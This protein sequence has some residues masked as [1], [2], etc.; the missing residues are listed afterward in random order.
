MSNSSEILHIND[1]LNDFAKRDNIDPEFALKLSQIRYS[2]LSKDII[3]FLIPKLKSIKLPLSELFYGFAK[4]FHK[5][6][7]R[8]IFT[9]AGKFRKSSDPN[10]GNIYFGPS[11]PRRSITV[12]YKGTAPLN[13]SQELNKIFKQLSS[14]D[15]NPVF[16]AVRFYQQ[17]VFIHPFYDANGRIGRLLVSLYLGYHGYAVLWKQ[18][19]TE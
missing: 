14:D 12:K 1:L 18:L 15:A 7:F 13:I 2:E 3:S 4:G 16:T 6:L 11:D 10:G 5:E 8:D 9:N 19:E 17:F